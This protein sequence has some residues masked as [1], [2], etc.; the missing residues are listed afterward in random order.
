MVRTKRALQIGHER[1]RCERYEGYPVN[2]VAIHTLLA[3][4]A[5]GKNASE[6]RKSRVELWQKLP[7]LYYGT[8]APTPARDTLMGYVSTCGAQK[9]PLTNRRVT[10]VITGL[11]GNPQFDAAGLRAAADL[12]PYGAFG[13]PRPERKV[14]EGALADGPIEHGIV[15]RLLVPYGDATITEVRLD[16]HALAESETDGYHLTRGPGVTVEIA[17]PPGR[18]KDFHIVSCNYDTPTQRR[19]GFTAADW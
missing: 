16:G 6:R 11:E 17:I 3:V 5:Y 14:E 18:M 13:G 10:K 1:A 2:Q 19:S 8:A 15:L 7:H 4:A 12:F 9:N